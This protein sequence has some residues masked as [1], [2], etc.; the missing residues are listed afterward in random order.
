MNA[1]LER[2]FID[3]NVLVYAHDLSAGEKN[4]RAGRLIEELW[5]T[6]QGCLSIQV[7]QEFY[8]TVTRKVPQPLAVTRA[9][10]IITDLGFWHI[11]TPGVTDILRAIDIQQKNRISFWDALVLQSALALGCKVV[12]SEDLNSGQLYDEVKVINPFVDL[13]CINGEKKL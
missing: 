8:V 4:T 5:E 6:H 10:Q 9:T 3:T 11:H 12:W 7:L 1:D 2:Q 13:G